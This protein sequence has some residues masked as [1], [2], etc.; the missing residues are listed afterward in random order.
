MK[1]VLVTISLMTIICMGCNSQKSKYQSI[2]GDI[3]KFIAD[4]ESYE[5]RIDD[6]LIKGEK[7]SPSCQDELKISAIKDREQK[8][9]KALDEIM[10]K[11][12]P[13]TKITEQ[14]S[15]D[16]NTGMPVVQSV[17]VVDIGKLTGTE[18]NLWYVL[19]SA[20]L[21][22]ASAVKMLSVSCQCIDGEDKN[23]VQ[24][25]MASAQMNENGRFSLGLASAKS[26]IMEA[27]DYLKKL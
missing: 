17:K 13:F 22:V 26:Y 27:K 3:E 14:E 25:V 2:A 21:S 16:P 23:S 18:Q 20:E 12:M 7:A 15:V 5:R 11:D 1:K 9:R 6:L 10:P 4:L 8:I 24:C 19:N